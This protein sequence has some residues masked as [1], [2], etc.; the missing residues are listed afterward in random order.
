MPRTLTLKQI[1][2]AK[3]AQE[4]EI[5]TCEAAIA[6]IDFNINVLNEKK[7]SLQLKKQ[8]AQDTL[9]ELMEDFP[10]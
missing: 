6:D 1:S 4:D 5:A 10:S 7:K 3:Q 8:M 9:N 2:L